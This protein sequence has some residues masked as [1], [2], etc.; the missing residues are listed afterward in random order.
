MINGVAVSSRFETFHTARK[1]LKTESLTD[2]SSC[3]DTET[4]RVA[5][6]GLAQ[7]R[8]FERTLSNLMSPLQAV[9]CASGS[10]YVGVNLG[11][12]AVFWVVYAPVSNLLLIFL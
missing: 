4:N 3:K 6:K 2:K 11:H 12:V 1:L 9:E 8:H 7:P 5:Y 10:H